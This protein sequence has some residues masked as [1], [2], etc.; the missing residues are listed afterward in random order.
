MT[1]LGP[2][3]TFSIRRWSRGSDPAVTRPKSIGRVSTSSIPAPGPGSGSG[4]GSGCGQERNATAP[5]PAM[6]R[7]ARRILSHLGQPDRGDRVGLFGFDGGGTGGGGPTGS[8]CAR[9]CRVTARPSTSPPDSRNCS[10]RRR[11]STPDAT[12]PAHTSSVPNSWSA[13]PRA[14]VSPLASAASRATASTLRNI[15]QRRVAPRDG[16]TAL[17]RPMTSAHCRC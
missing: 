4:S 7:T 12:R 5:I 3:P 10:A 16:V 14:P 15:P 13:Q 2:V 17:A 8:A 1:S 6:M 9:L 11:R